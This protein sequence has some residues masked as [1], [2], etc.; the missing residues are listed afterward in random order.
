MRGLYELLVNAP[1]GAANSSAVYPSGG[2]GKLDLLAKGSP[3]GL[4]FKARTVRSSWVDFADSAVVCPPCQY[5]L[6]HLP[7]A[8]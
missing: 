2:T 6:R 3:R 1:E 7:G 5:E 8:I 4:N